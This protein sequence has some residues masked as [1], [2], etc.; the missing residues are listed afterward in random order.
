MK[1]N[2]RN[3]A[4]AVIVAI[5]LLG[6]QTTVFADDVCKMIVTFKNETGKKFPL[7]IV[8]RA[9]SL[10][11]GAIHFSPD[12]NVP[13]GPGGSATFTATFPCNSDKNHVDFAGYIGQS[14]SGLPT[15]VETN[16]TTV[17]QPD[18]SATANWDKVIKNDLPDKDKYR[19]S[20]VLSFTGWKSS[21]M[22]HQISVI[23][24]E[25]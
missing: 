9:I 2:I 16:W 8:V 22:A 20:L 23:E 7:P 10:P 17:Y 18:G 5:V 21:N 13:V 11:Q 24:V 14:P 25:H 12:D 3:K 4:L 1:K 6:L 15:Y 19:Y